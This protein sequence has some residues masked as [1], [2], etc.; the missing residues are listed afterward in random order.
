MRMTV[1][2]A[3]V[4]APR[5]R[6]RLGLGDAFADYTLD[7]SRI[8]RQGWN[9]THPFFKAAIR[10]VRPRLI[11][12]LGV[13][14]GMSSIEMARLMKEEGLAGEILCIDTWLGSSNHLSQAD[15]RDE[16][17]P[18]NGYPTVYQTFLANVADAGHGD[19]ITPLA[20]DGNSAAFALARLGVTADVI[21]IDASHEYVAAIGDLRNYW[22]LLSAAGMLIA[23]DYGAWPG[24]TRAVCEFAAEVD[25][26]VFGSMGKAMIPKDPTLGFEMQFVRTKRYKRSSHKN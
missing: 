25:R 26:P 21:H 18:V 19:V 22:P 6:D 8:D 2:T 13:W 7:P 17:R 11:I 20:M 3:D 4:P 12:E 14:K 16:L 23:D 24:V 15:R 1:K 5:L 10:L 9:S